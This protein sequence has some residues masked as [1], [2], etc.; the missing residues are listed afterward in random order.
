MGGQ[1]AGLNRAP[2]SPLQPNMPGMPANAAYS[3]QTTATIAKE[4][5]DTGASPTAEGLMK[6]G[7]K[8][9]AGLPTVRPKQQLLYL[10]DVLGFQ[11]Q[12]TDF[13]KGTNKTEYLSLVSLS[14]NPPQVSHGSGPSIDASHD[15]AALTALKALSELGLDIAEKKDVDTMAAG[16]GP[17]VKKEIGERLA[18][19]ADRSNNSTATVTVKTEPK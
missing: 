14:T 13:P 5:L 12:F 17:H 9:I 4:L 19:S 1:G 16:D 8:P 6:T 11:V 18:N 15:M 10:A 2:G 3:T 7:T